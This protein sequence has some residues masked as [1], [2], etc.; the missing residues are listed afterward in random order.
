MTGSGGDREHEV[1]ALPEV[2]RGYPGY[3]RPGLTPARP[4]EPRFATSRGHALAYDDV[5]SGP[6]VVLLHGFTLSGGDWWETG[7]VD[8]LL[9]DG[10]RVIVLDPLGHG[11]SDGPHEPAAYRYPDV[12]LDIRSVLDA[13][14]IDRAAVW[15]YSR[16]AGL[17]AS[18][19]I[20]APERVD[21]LVVG[22]CAGM[23]QTPPAALMDWQTRLL[24]GDW[25]AYW[26]TPVGQGYS[27][28]ERRYAESLCDPSALAAALAG[29]RLFPYE[30][31]LASVRCPVLLYVGADDGNPEDALA[32]AAALRTTPVILPGLDHGSAI[33]EAGRVWERVGPFLSGAAEP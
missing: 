23:E 26:Q 20:E 6:P 8:L 18:L 15:G 27:A 7:A 19:A 16:G 33:A 1:A 9:A 4:I 21:R 32:T 25:Q 31:R 30:L 5:G 10:F 14:G 2:R 22:G 24:A 29:R 3:R 11:Q 17:A 28:D 12:A 13:A